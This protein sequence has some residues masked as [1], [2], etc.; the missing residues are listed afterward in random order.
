MANDLCNDVCYEVPDYT[1][2]ECFLK[3]YSHQV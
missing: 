3:W 2:H 1:F